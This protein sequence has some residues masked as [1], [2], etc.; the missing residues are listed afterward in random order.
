MKIYIQGLNEDTWQGAEKITWL[1]V[2][3]TFFSG[4]IEN[5]KLITFM[6][7]QEIRENFDLKKNAKHYHRSCF[8]KDC[9]K[10]LRLVYHSNI[11][12]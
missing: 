4:G 2:F 7:N 10:T 9:R 1:G 6:L 5:E 8:T 12:L 3:E 11:N